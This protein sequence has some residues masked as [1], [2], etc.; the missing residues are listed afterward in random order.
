MNNVQFI[1]NNGKREYAILP[2][3]LYERLAALVEEATDAQALNDF[4]LRDDGFRIPDDLLRRELAGES[5]VKLWREYRGLTIEGL[6]ERAGVAVA[7]IRQIEK[8]V[9]APEGDLLTRLA[10]KMGIPEQV[11]IP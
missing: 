11:L 10:K 5:P 1:E 3:A 9:L 4:H 7:E 2:Y 6:A 8:G